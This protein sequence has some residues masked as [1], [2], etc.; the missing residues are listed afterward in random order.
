[1]G[2]CDAVGRLGLVEVAGLVEAALSWQLCRRWGYVERGALTLT[3]RLRGLT[4]YGIRTVYLASNWVFAV[5]T[6]SLQ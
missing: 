4:K 3:S 2:F 6:G 5:F 1:M